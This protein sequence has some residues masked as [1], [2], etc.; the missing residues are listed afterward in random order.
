MRSVKHSPD[1]IQEDSHSGSS[2]LG[3]L[4]SQ[5]DDQRLNIPPWDIRSLRFLEDSVEGPLVLSIHFNKMVSQCDI[6]SS[7][8]VVSLPPNVNSTGNS[9]RASRAMSCRVEVVVGSLSYGPIVMLISASLSF[10]MMKGSGSFKNAARL[11]G[12]QLPLA[13]FTRR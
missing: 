2:A 8:I 12:H 1:T 10:G 5:S 9:E 6:T 3:Y 4:S 13:A 11:I 7:A